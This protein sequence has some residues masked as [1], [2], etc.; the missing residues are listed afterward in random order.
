MLNPQLK[1]L[2]AKYRTELKPLIAEYESRNENFVTPL[3]H[4]IPSM[5]D[6]IALYEK[7]TTAEEKEEY[8]ADAEKCLD[9]AIENLRVCLVAS[10]MKDVNQFKSRFSQK[11]LDALDNGKFSGRFFGLEKEVRTLKDTNLQAT[12]LKLKEM[13]DMIAGCHAGTL[14][15]GLLSD[16]KF[17]TAFKWFFTIVIALLINILI[18]KWL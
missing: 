8:R 9:K 6:N 12:Y 18:L 5:F 2:Y 3:L 1:S 11:T 16:S 15:M 17:I 14:A 10:M 13:K 7:A 4:D